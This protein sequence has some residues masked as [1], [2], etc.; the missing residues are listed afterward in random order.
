MCF[1]VFISI[2]VLYLLLL[3]EEE[4]CAFLLVQKQ[5]FAVVFSKVE[6]ELQKEYN[7]LSLSMLM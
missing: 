5:I 2:T 4:I 6:E 3:S 1:N 7:H